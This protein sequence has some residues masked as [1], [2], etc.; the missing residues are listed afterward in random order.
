MGVI[1]Q[2]LEKKTLIIIINV[3]VGFRKWG[4]AGW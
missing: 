2:I 3:D 1:Y 4:R